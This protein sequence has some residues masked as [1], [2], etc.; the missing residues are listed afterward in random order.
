[1]PI[2]ITSGVDNSISGVGNDRA[3]L[4]P[5][6]STARPSGLSKI[7]AWFNPAAFKTNAVGT[8]G[9][10]PRNY[11]RGPGYE[12]LD[13]SLFKDIFAE[14][15]IHGQFQAEAFNALNHTNLANPAS[16]ASSGGTFGVISATSSSTGTVNIPSP[17]GT[18]RVWQ[19]V[20]KIIF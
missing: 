3:D 14:H 18:Q 1:M 15:R 6:V 17:V 5:G 8:F 11:L 16:S 4:V 10:V 13:L 2:N 9:N 20:G 7:Q 19:F 12:D